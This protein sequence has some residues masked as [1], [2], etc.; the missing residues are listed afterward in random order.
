M[1]TYHIWPNAIPGEYVDE[2][3]LEH[4]SPANKTTN[5]AVL[6]LP[7]G[8]YSYRAPHEGVGYAEF[9][10]EFGLEAFILAYR[11]V[12]GRKMNG[13]PL[14][15]YPL[16]DARRAM[17]YLRANAE[18]LG[19]DTD[20]IAVIGSSAGGPLAAVVSTYRGG[21]EGEGVDALDEL[22]YLPNAQILCYPVITS[23]LAVTH[24][25][26]YVNLLGNLFEERDAYS[27]DLIADKQTPPAFLWHTA[28]DNAVN[29]INSY[30]YATTLRNLEIP[31]E[32]HIF[33][34]GNHG[35]GV[36]ANDPH[37]HQ[38]VGLLKNWL[39]LIGFLPS[40]A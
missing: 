30:R 25:G 1:N 24:K 28:A 11:T 2:P 32:M 8:G 38:W 29:V 5:A 35:R 10:N 23:D 20:K 14:F 34:F 33:P 17:R 31:C 26:S 27:P 13:T 37:L 21:V 6:I 18:A 15:P 19:I 12:S 4:Y 9:F 39:I 36:A 7:G 16:L 22:D 40:E 3:I